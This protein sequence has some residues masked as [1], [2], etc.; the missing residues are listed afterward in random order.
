MAKIEMFYKKPTW[1]RPECV[2][3]YDTSS[4]DEAEVMFNAFRSKDTF[5]SPC[6]MREKTDHYLL[7]V[8][9]YGES[10]NHERRDFGGYFKD[11]GYNTVHE[12]FKAY[13]ADFNTRKGKALY[14]AHKI[15]WGIKWTATRLIFLALALSF[16]Y[17]VGNFKS[18][19]HDVNVRLGIEK[20]VVYK[21]VATSYEARYDKPGKEWCG[22]LKGD[23]VTC[24]KNF[25]KMMEKWYGKNEY[26]LNPTSHVNY[27][28]E[29][30]S[31]YLYSYSFS[32]VIKRMMFLYEKYPYITDCDFDVVYYSVFNGK[33][34][35]FNIMYERGDVRPDM[36]TDQIGMEGFPVSEADSVTLWSTFKRIVYPPYGAEQER[37]SRKHD[38]D[39]AAWCKKKYAERDEYKEKYR[40]DFIAHKDS[41]YK[42]NN[43]K[44]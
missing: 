43:I 35:S 2:Y 15:K 7:C 10:R 29:G 12:L 20:E 13:G 32:D 11:Y 17:I 36:S 18:V 23:Y 44:Y 6:H 1:D 39:V 40:A 30:N 4:D 38:E 33:D 42:Q 14:K 3:R 9:T 8:V 37:L 28:I 16:G 34:E 21:P 25:E 22:E 19:A 5:M 26:S 31:L 24:R 41:L 27:K